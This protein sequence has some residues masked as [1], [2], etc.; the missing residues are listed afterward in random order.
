MIFEEKLKEEFELVIVE[1]GMKGINKS[2]FIAR[3]EQVYDG[4]KAL[5]EGLVTE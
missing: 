3:C 2:D 5:G 1:V 4:I